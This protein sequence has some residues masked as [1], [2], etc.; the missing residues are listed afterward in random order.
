[1]PPED[2]N[3]AMANPGSQATAVAEHL[4]GH[5]G[6]EVSDVQVL[7]LGVVRVGRHDGVDWVARIF[8]SARPRDDVAAEAAILQGL[9]RHG[10][11]AERCA[12]AE[13]VSSLRDQSVLVT[14]YLTPA[15]PLKPGR[16]AAIL[17]AL[18]GGL[19]TNA[20][21]GLRAGGAWH[22]LSHTGGPREE[23][24]AAEA[25]LEDALPRVPVR[26][27]ALYDELCDAVAASDDC[28]DLPH[29]FVHPDFVPANA[30]PTQDDSLVVVDWT[31][32]G[33]GPRLWSIGF[34]LWA[35]GA[36]SPRV[37]ELV[38]SRYRRRAA[39][40]AEELSRLAGAIRGRP[41]MLECWAFGTG[42]RSL[43]EA[44]QRVAEITEKSEQIAALARAAFARP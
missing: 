17:G 39:L 30:I 33:R 28:H 35:A 29:A 24:A 15:A 21:E 22:H 1:M 3:A 2:D 5:Y 13:P 37:L 40:E 27:L 44:V 36:R 4:A 16:P 38:I 9:E 18:L 8:P 26:E 19:H 25:L 32:A 43:A 7:D 6:I 20:G 31:G 12:H 11:P 41:V 42:R 34:L 23:I 10:F 14:E